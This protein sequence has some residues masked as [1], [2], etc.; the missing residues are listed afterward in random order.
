[1]P[2]QATKARL[3]ADLLD[4]ARRVLGL[5][6]DAAGS[7]IVRAALER[8]TGAE[9]GSTRIKGGRPPNART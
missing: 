5:P 4:A 9:P 2:T 6:P 8:L 7:E 3:S 1:M